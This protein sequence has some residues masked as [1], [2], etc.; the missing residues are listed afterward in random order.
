MIDEI[1][2]EANDGR[3]GKELDRHAACILA[4]VGLTIWMDECL[5]KPA[6][7]WLGRELDH[8]LT[9]PPVLAA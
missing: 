9:K 1:Y 6:V 2:S 3:H 4:L 5:E 8:R 7:E